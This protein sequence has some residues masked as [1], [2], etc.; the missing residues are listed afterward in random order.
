M[1]IQ[2]NKKSP[3]FKIPNVISMTPIKKEQI[4]TAYSQSNTSPMLKVLFAT[5]GAIAVTFWTFAFMQQL[6]S[7]DL[8]AFKT[9]TNPI[10]LAFYQNKMDSDVEVKQRLPPPPKPVAHPPRPAE[11]SNPTVI[12]SGMSFNIATSPITF[13]NPPIMLTPQDTGATPIVRS[14]PKYPITAAKE[15]IEGWVKLNFTISDTGQ[16]L[17]ANVI[18]AEPKRMFNREAVKALKRWKY[19]P[20]MVNGKAIIQ[21]NQTIVLE[22][23]LQK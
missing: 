16:V 21:P 10:E 23:K 7:Q 5:T 9:A 4:M 18:D 19:R 2:K 22:F 17:D 13:D 12:D 6:I 3:L 1:I 15:G 20:K 8:P 11:T 14:E